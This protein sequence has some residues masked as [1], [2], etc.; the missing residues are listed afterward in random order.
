[1]NQ[2]W[3][4]VIFFFDIQIFIVPLRLTMR[5]VHEFAVQNIKREKKK[6]VLRLQVFSAQS[7]LSIQL[8]L[9]I[10]KVNKFFNNYIPI[11][12]E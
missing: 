1:M 8:Q 10:H 5:K 9:N 4:L 11:E 7:L 12:E 3:R 6:I 2:L